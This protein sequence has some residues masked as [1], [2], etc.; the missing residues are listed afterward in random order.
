MR[1]AL[2]GIIFLAAT[3][4]V[5][6]EVVVRDRGGDVATV[7]SNALDVNINGTV[8]VSG[9]VSGNLT[10]LNSVAL[11]SPVSSGAAT[12][13]TS[14][15]VIPNAALLFNYNGANWVP[16]NTTDVVAVGGNVAHDSADSGN[17]NKVGCKAIA[18]GSTPTAVTA[19]DRSDVYCNRA[20]V[21]FVGQHPNT[22]VFYNEYTATQADTAIV[23]VAAGTKVVVQRALISCGDSNTSDISFRLGFGTATVP[24]TGSA[25]IVLGSAGLGSGTFSGKAY[26]GPW[27]AGAD[28]EDLRLDL[29]EPEGTCDIEVAYFTIAG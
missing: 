7:T 21:L 3:F 4:A 23:T 12:I 28:D 8:P 15:T 26:T 10:Q 9:T 20:G 14:Q 18:Y 25:G 11:T 17:P 29:S 22:V 6:Q 13:D 2:L 5:A 24:A 27:V 1:R 19:N 16:V